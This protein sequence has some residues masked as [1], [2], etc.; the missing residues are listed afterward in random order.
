MTRRLAARARALAAAASLAWLGGAAPPAA[1]AGP[2]A[3]RCEHVVLVIFGGGVRTKEFLG[4]PDLLPNVRQIGA[5]GL[6]SAGWAR[7]GDTHEGASAAILT[8]VDQPGAYDAGRPPPWPTVLEYARKG[9]S[10]SDRDAWFASYADGPAL[11]L[12]ASAHG[13]YG[14]ASAPG[15]AYG[16][17]PFG[18]P[19]RSLLALYGRPS[20][21]KEATWALLAGL[22]AASSSDEV[23]PR[24]RATPVLDPASA[25]ALRLETALLEEVDRRARDIAG[26]N[27]QDA[28]AVRA[29]A[30]VLRAFRPRLVVVRLGQADVAHGNLFSYWDVLKRNDAEVGRL[31]AVIA[32][33]PALRDTTALFVVPDMG[34]DEEQNA[35]GGYDHADGS[36]D[37]TTVAVVAEGA[38]IRRGA[39]PKGRPSVRDLCP[40]IG[41][42][43][44][45]P[46]P[47]AQGVAREE[48]L[49]R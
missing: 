17:G 30:F 2:A 49:Q 27:A 39:T 23:A 13:E 8:G 11:L 45:F 20:P 18:E 16:D 12:A 32:A 24:A 22:R 28:R 10:L 29:A 7:G 41:R 21:T 5:A 35:G 1:R 15:L 9:L 4:R 37:A 14:R 26:A 44:G 40:T 6:A 48:L 46:T 33:D 31:R 38:G 36:A 19:M 3:P 42:L 43:L 47:Y 34:R 25:E